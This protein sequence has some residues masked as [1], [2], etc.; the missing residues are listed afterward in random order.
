MRA[1]AHLGETAGHLSAEDSAEIL[2][3]LDLY[4]PIP[5]FDGISAENLLAR[6]VHDKKTIRGDVHFVLPVRIGEAEVVSG[7]DERVALAAIRYA[8]T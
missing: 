4:G 8:L 7:V 5:P 2:E 3:M 6:L 1:A